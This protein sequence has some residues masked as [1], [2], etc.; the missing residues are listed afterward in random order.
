MAGVDGGGESIARDAA[1][2]A[3]QQTPQRALHRTRSE[4]PRHA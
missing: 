1:D 2:M 3:H 4:G